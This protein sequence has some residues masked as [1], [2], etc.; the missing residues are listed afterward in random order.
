MEE[1][2][3]KKYPNYPSRLASLYVSATLEEALKWYEMFTEW[4]RPTYSIVKVVVDG[5]I[6]VGDSWNCL[7]GGT[8]SRKKI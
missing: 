3:K 6:Y 2:R 4:G 7:D 5:N 8:T 1:V